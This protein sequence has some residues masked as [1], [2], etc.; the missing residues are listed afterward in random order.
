MDTILDH[1]Q[2]QAAIVSVLS[3]F[4]KAQPLDD[5]R[6]E[7]VFDLQQDRYQVMALGTLD[8][9]PFHECLAYITIRNNQVCLE[10]DVSDFGLPDALQ[11]AGIPETALVFGMPSIN[12]PP[13]YHA[14]ATEF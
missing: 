8:N 6:L 10:I 5:I 11:Q 4:A 12:Q 13:T 2:T 1:K 9:K 14:R 3:E 7:T